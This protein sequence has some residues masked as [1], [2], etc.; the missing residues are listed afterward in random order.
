MGL[1]LRMIR[2]VMA[3]IQTGMERAPRQDLTQAVDAIREISGP[4]VSFNSGNSWPV[5]SFQYLTHST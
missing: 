4:L 3:A 1:L 5:F 2:N